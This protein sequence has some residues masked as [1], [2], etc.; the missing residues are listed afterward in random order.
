MATVQD[1]APTLLRVLTAAADAPKKP[2]ID[3]TTVTPIW[4]S[5]AEHF[6]K[7][8]PSGSGNN[9]CDPFVVSTF[10]DVFIYL[11]EYFQILK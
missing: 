2:P 10:C 5:Y 7:P 9:R 1:K 4:D 11:T 6:S 3:S 8:I